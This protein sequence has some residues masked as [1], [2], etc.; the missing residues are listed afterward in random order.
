MRWRVEI[1]DRGG[2]DRLLRDVLETNS[3]QLEEE[4]GNQ[5]LVG[6]AFEAFGTA[7]EVYEFASRVQSIVTEIG[8]AD[9]DILMSFQIGGVVEK[10]ENGALRTH[11]FMTGRVAS[12]SS[13]TALLSLT[14]Q[15]G[16]ALS[17]VDR[18]RI[19]DEQKELAYQEKRLRAS[20]R[21]V[22]ALKDERAL[23]VQRLLRKDLNPL[24]MGHIADII[25]DDMCGAM[26]NFVS[27]KQLTR[28]YRSIN[29]PTVFGEQSR[30]IA[31]KHKPPRNPMSLDE[32]R[33]FIRDLAA[34]WL[35]HKA[36]LPRSI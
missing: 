25:Q 2:D 32:A 35:E 34:R 8:Q 29:H 30:H 16:P 10:L 21:V 28:F 31:S 9:P 23:Q 1:N 11:V 14:V 12:L 4:A 17:D 33:R 6:D 7:A 20:A 13:A 24:R 22:S 36:G 3:I 15:R 18:K 27:D 5:S 26:K 19:E